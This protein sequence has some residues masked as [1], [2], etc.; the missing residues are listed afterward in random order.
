MTEILHHKGHSLK[1]KGIYI[2]FFLVK[3]KNQGVEKD[4]YIMLKSK[5]T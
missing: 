5:T 1:I 4:K 2:N 3:S